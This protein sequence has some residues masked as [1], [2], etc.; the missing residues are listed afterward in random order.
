MIIIDISDK[1]VYFKFENKRKNNKNTPYET[2]QVTHETCDWYLVI[3]C[4][5]N[6]Q[7]YPMVLNCPTCHNFV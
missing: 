3:N 7:F 4:E 1:I 6:H 2:C 5:H